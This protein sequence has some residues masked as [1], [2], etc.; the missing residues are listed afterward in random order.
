MAHRPS[1]ARWFEVVVA[2]QDAD[3]AMEALARI[4]GIQFEWKADRSAATELGTLRQCVSR[5]RALA[6]DYAQLWPT[7]VF[8]KRCC[9]QSLDVSAGQAV[10]GMEQWRDKAA[11]RLA[12]LGRLRREQTELALWD[13]ILQQ[14]GCDGPDLA[15]LAGAGPV[16]RGVCLSLAPTQDVG[17]PHLLLQQALQV[18]ERRVLLGLA[19]QNELQQLCSEI[20]AAGG[21]CLDLPGWLE[22]SSEASR[23]RLRERRDRLEHRISALEDQLHSLAA[24]EG[25]DR[26]A[27]VLERID[28]FCRHAECIH[29]DGEYCWITGWTSEQD[30]DAMNRALRDVAVEA[31]LSLP[32]PPAD[33]PAPSLTRHPLW[34]EAFEVFPRAVGVPGV[35]EADPTIWVAFLVPLMFGYMCGDVGHGALIFLVGILLRSRTRLWPLLVFAGL[36][37]TAF[38]FVYGE[39]FGYEHF[40]EPLWLRPIDEPFSV[41]LAPILFGALVLNLGVL[42]HLVG[43]CWRGKGR[44]EGVA[45]V[46]QLLVYWGVI[47]AFA[48]VRLGWLA[49]AG[50]VLCGANR[51]WVERS[52]LALLSGLGSLVYSSFELLLHTLSFIRVGAFALAHA[53][54]Q[55]AV[56]AIADAVNSPAVAVLVVVL[57]NLAVVAVEGFVVSIQTT[58]LVLFEFFIH[59][60]KG[61]GRGFQPA[62]RPPGSR[63][64]G[65]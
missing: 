6:A 28:W 43:T 12:Q 53:A 62:D 11:A 51:L 52:L 59:F 8:E 47:L 18:G 30:V 45:D 49:V 24:E 20:T 16:L 2:R 58:R 41:L 40:I 61:E 9:L 3:D 19:P 38:G 35:E 44:S 7:P 63:K 54:L 25:V 13:P 60:F 33:V 15:A 23:A 26:Y 57:G 36:A 21:A 34:L 42:L 22:S 37:A 46:A 31:R 27:G 5:Y 1:P 10:A 4:G 48:D 17:L 14:L 65:S 29:C 55:S 64:P 56:F 39:V 32:E 50:T